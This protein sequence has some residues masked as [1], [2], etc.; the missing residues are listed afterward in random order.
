VAFN[1]SLPP[2]K[3]KNA[4]PMISSNNIG[5]ISRIEKNKKGQ[6]EIVRKFGPIGMVDDFQNNKES[7]SCKISDIG[8]L[9]TLSTQSARKKIE[10]LRRH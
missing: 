7:N 2:S 10:L 3:Q 9:R 4:L 8:K 5:S 6:V 1:K